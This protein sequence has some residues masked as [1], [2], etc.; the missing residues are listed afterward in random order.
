MNSFL[1]IMRTLIHWSEGVI[2]HYGYAGIALLTA[3]EQFIQPVPADLYIGLGTK[4]GFPFERV[5]ATVMIFAFIGSFIGYFLGKYLGHPAF[6]WLFG[7][8]KLDRGER[9][10]KKWGMWG[11]I[12]AGFTPIPFKIVTWTAG[13]FEMPLWKFTIGLLLGRIP[14]YLLVGLGGRWVIQNHFFVGADFGAVFLGVL[15]GV[16]EFLPISSS[17]HLALVE[18]FMKLPYS[19]DQMVLFDILIHSGSLLAIVIYFWREIAQIFKDLWAMIKN[20]KIILD[21]LVGKLILGTIPAVIAGVF[22]AHFFTEN[23]RDKTS[24]AL[25]FLFMGL[26]FCYVEWR[27]KKRTVHHDITPKRATMIGFAQVFAMISAISR[28]GMTIGGAMLMGV[29]REE[30]ARFSFL[31]GGVAILAANLWALLN[32]ETGAPMPDLKFTVI[33][34]VTTFVASYFTIAWLIKYL[35]TRTLIP[36]ALYLMILGGVILTLQA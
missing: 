25:C 21:S 15:Q 28:S 5:L 30:A 16:T 24:L 13:I 19:L 26:F 7:Q 2:A 12:V 18:P 6:R 31:L 3:T 36:F 11:V 33:G 9:F 1:E 17:G 32:L 4:A 35:K 14:R 23:F 27:S 10:I 29:K 20:R 8:A 34:T 22:F